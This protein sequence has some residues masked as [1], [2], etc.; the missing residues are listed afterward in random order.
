MSKFVGINSID[1]LRNGFIHLKLGTALQ[2][3]IEGLYNT[4]MRWDGGP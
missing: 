3:L 2:K 4:E 1:V